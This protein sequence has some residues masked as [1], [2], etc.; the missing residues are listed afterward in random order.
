M[1]ILFI[2]KIIN[3]EE[4]SNTHS[5]CIE[6]VEIPGLLFADDICLMATS[7]I[8]LQRKID[9]VSKFCTKWDL[10]INIQKTKVLTGENGCKLSSKEIWYLQGNKIKTVKRNI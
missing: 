10:K 5:L 7:R 2:D 1:F 8:G 9:Y 6:N 4:L 3:E